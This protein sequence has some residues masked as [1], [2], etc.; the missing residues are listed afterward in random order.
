MSVDLKWR[1]QYRGT[2]CRAQGVVDQFQ[3]IGA[4][5]SLI[6]KQK[7]QDALPNNI[8]SGL[9]QGRMISTRVLQ[10]SWE[11][12]TFSSSLVGIAAFMSGNIPV[13]AWSL[14]R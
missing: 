14:T 6:I 3:R 8:S 5:N 7:K 2:Y 11:R 9:W 10:S 13:W 4:A 12:Q 1:L